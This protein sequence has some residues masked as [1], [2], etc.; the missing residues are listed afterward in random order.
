MKSENERQAEFL[1]DYARH[2]GHKTLQEL[3]QSALDEF[4]AIARHWRLLRTVV[5]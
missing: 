3:L 5:Q 4:M 1:A 2:H